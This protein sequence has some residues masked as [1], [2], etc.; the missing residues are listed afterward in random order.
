MSLRELSDRLNKVAQ[1]LKHSSNEVNPE[2]IIEEF[3]KIVQIPGQKNY[4][5]YQMMES[6]D[7]YGKISF[8]REFTFEIPIYYQKKLGMT[9]DVGKHYSQYTRGQKLFQSRDVHELGRQVVLQGRQSISS[10]IQN[11]LILN[12]L[13]ANL[14]LEGLSR[15]ELIDP[16]DH[17]K[18]MYFTVYVSLSVSNP[19][20]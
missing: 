19:L 5:D 12:R 1:V 20:R 15:S 18:G 9:V 17:T 6:K 14:T 10:S 7:N 3:L 2:E 16:Q 11:K 13:S 4:L 8:Y